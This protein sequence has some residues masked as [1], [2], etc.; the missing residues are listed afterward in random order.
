MIDAWL[1][2][3]RGLCVDNDAGQYFSGMSGP[4]SGVESRAWIWFVGSP[5]WRTPTWDAGRVPALLYRFEERRVV[6]LFP[7]R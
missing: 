6:G 1:L 2:L 5:E 7:S 4:G 3:I